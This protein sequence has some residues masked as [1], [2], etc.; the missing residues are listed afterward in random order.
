[1]LDLFR[2]ELYRI[3]HKRNMYLFL[4]IVFFA[5]LAITFMR[6]NSF[7][8][9]SVVTDAATM[10]QLMPAVLGG[11]FFT[12]V[13]TDDLSAKNLITLVGYGTSRTKIVLTKLALM[14]L[15]TVICF[16]L[17][18]LLH[19]GAYAVFGFAATASQI[20][21][22]GAVIVQFI[23]MTL[24]FAAVAAIVVYGTQKPTFA[25]VTYFMLAFNVVTMLINAAS[26]L[27]NVNLSAH[28]I[29][30][31]TSQMM[32]GF[33]APGGNVLAPLLEYLGYVVLAVVAA[34]ILFK[35]REME[36]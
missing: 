22:V 21:L 2:G 30:G 33:A 9:D 35:N 6:A 18:A 14:A 20:R 5:Y 26:S 12:A 34:I 4:G 1:M 19:L 8:P 29:S 31:T 11:Y 28:L 27:L 10:L 13:F 32:M 15:F 23:L 3:L 7:G 24:G 16:V 36:F 17:I 25:V